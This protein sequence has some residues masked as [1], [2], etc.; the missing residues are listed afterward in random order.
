MTALL[1]ASAALAQRTGGYVPAPVSVHGAPAELEGVDID[2]KK[3]GAALPLDLP[4]VNEEG[5]TITLRNVLR[6]DR[7]A[8]LQL[9]Y[10]RCPMLCS[11]VLDGFAA[12]IRET[13]LEPGHDFTP[14]TVSFDPRDTPA[15][16][17]EV[18]ERYVAQAARDGLDESWRFLTGEARQTRR[19]AEA[20]GFEYERD[21]HTGE[22]AHPAVLIFL[23][24][25]GRVTRYLYGASFAERDFRLALVEAGEGRVGNTLDRFILTCYRYDPNQRSYTPYA[26][27]ALRVGGGIFLVVLVGLL[28]PLM[29]RDRV[30]H[31]DDPP[32]TA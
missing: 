11:L 13:G 30:K 21:A 2:V 1:L 6:P 25:D 18:R 16:A 29:R 17:A 9:G 5:R 4:F 28:V 12:A 10:M 32:A 27:G 7:P 22:Y 15:R 8:I 31:S 3:L 23:A 20:V 14:V 26:M 24:P 19:L